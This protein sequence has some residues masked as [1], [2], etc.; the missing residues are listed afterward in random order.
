MENLVANQ[1]KIMGA[2]DQ[3][4]S[5]YKKDGPDRKTTYHIKKRLSTLESYWQEFQCNHIKLCEYED[6]SHE[7][8]VS[9]FYKRTSEFYQETRAYI[10]NQLSASTAME[11]KPYHS[12]ATSLTASEFEQQQQIAGTSRAE[13]PTPLRQQPSSINV[14]QNRGTISKLEE[15]LRKQ[16]S[17][18]RAFERTINIINFE[19]VSEKWEFEDIL[20]SIHSRWSV[21]DSLH[22]EIDSELFEPNEEYEQAFSK[23]EKRF[24]DI[25]RFINSKMW[26]QVNREKATPQMD[27][28]TFSGSYHSWV[29]FKDLFTETIHSNKSLSKAQKMQFLKSKLKGEAEKLIQH[30]NI[31]SDNY[32]ISWDI[33]NHRFNNTK[34]I[35]NSHLSILMNLPTLQQQTATSI[36]KIHD[37]TNEC[38]NAIRSLGVQIDSWDPIIVYIICN[39][40]DAD[41][42]NDYIES[43][44]NPRDL[45]SLK[46]L[47]D[48][49]ESKFT[50][51]ESS[52]RKPET[53]K[54]YHTQETTNNNVKKPHY[55]KSFA[56]RQK[57]SAKHFATANTSKYELQGCPVCKKDHG[58][59][60]CDTFLELQPNMKQQTITKLSLCKNCLY[61]HNDKECRS[62]KK[63]RVCKEDHN[64]LLHDVFGKVSKPQ[65]QND[66]RMPTTQYKNN[67]LQEEAGEVLLATALVKVRA[68]DGSY[69]TLRALIDQGS[70]VGLI[71]ENAA[72]LLGLQRKRC[73]G[74]I[75]G[76]GAKESNCKGLASLTISSMHNDYTF[77]TDVFI[78]KQLIN[79]LPN[80]SFVKPSWPF[81]EN[82]N[83]ADPEF[84]VSRQVDILLGADTYSN[85]ILSGIIRENNT[86]PIAQQSQ[87]G[88]ILFGCANTTES[89]HCNVALIDDLDIQRFWTIEDVSDNSPLSA[90]DQLCLEYYKSTTQRQTDGTY[91]V[92]L[93]LHPDIDEKLGMSRP[94]A[95][96]QFHQLE[97]KFQKQPNVAD[98]YKQFMEEYTKLG[99]MH[100]TNCNSTE[101]YY[102]AHHCVQ[103]PG[104]T[105]SA[106]RVVY[107]ASGATTTG[108]SLN[109]LMY[110]GP[111][112]QQDLLS[113][114]IRWR[115]YKY[116]FTADLEKM[117]RQILVHPDD[118][119]YQKIVWRPSPDQFLQDY[120]LSTVTYG[121]KAAPFLAM[122]TLRQLATDE[123][124]KFPIAAKALA[125]Q[126]YMDDLLSGSHNIETAKQLQSDLLELLKSANFNLRKWSSNEKSLLEHVNND[127]KTQENFDF[128]HQESTKALGLVWVPKSDVFTFQNKTTEKSLSKP[129]KRALLAEISKTF[130]PLGWLAPVTL[131]L[132]LLFQEVWVADLNWDDKIPDA[133]FQAWLKIKDD[134]ANINKIK[135]PRWIHSKQKS[136]IQLHG[137]SD[138]SMKGYSS[139][140]YARVENQGV[141]SVTLLVA[142]TKI[143]PTSKSKTEVSLPRL[144]LCGAQLLSKLMDKITPCLQ[145][146]DLEIYGWTDSTAVLGWL[147]GEP[148]RWKPFVANRVQKITKVMPPEC[149][150]YIKTKENPADCASRGMSVEQLQ[151]HSLWWNGPPALLNF[152]K[153]GKQEQS[154]FT[155]DL[156]ARKIIHTNVT[157]TDTVK[158]NIIQQLIDK[159]STFTR[160]YRVLAWIRRA[161]SRD[162][163][164][165]PYL[166]A[167]ELRSAKLEII[168]HMQHQQYSE[169]ISNLKEN[170]SVNSKSNILSLNPFLDENDLL[171][172]K[173]R[174]RNAFISNEMKYPLII[175]HRGQLTNLL[176]DHAHERTLHGT[177]RTTTSR[178]RE[179]YWIVGGN[180]AVKNRLQ[181]CVTCKKQKAK[182]LQQLM[183]DLPASR[184]NPSR[185]FYHTGVDYTGF[186][187]VKSSKGRGIKST[188]GYVAVFVCMVTKA[189]HLELV[190]DLTASAFLAALRRMSA[191]RGAPR[192]LYSDNGTN[193]IGS[194]KKLQGEILDM[195]AICTKE[196]FTDISEMEITWH[197]NAPSWPS[198]GGL[199]EA[200]VKSLKHHLRRVVGDQKLTYEEYATLLAQIEACLNARPLCAISEDPDDINYLTP[201]HF[202]AS[203]PTLTIIETERDERTRWELTQRIFHDLWKR[204][205]VEYLSQLSAR[206]KWRSTQP[207]I[208][209]DDVVIIHDANLAASKWALGRVIE[210]HPGKDGLVRVVSLKT[211]A[212]I[213]KRPVV[214]LSIL[215]TDS[216]ETPAQSQQTQENTT[217]TSK[218]KSGSKRT[219][220]IK[221][222]CINFM[223]TIFLLFMLVTTSAAQSAYNI[224]ALPISNGIYFDKVS[225]MRLVQDQWKLVVY[226]NMDPYWQG[227][228]VLTG[229]Y[230]HLQSMC[231]LIIERSH[232]DIILLQLQHGFVEL[233]HYDSIL[234]YQQPP[235]TTRARRG[236]IDGVGYLAHTLF[237]VLDERFAEQYQKDITMLRNKQSHLTQYWKKQTSIVEA[238]NNLLKR[239]EGTIEKQHK[240]FNQHLLKLENAAN[241]M[242]SEVQSIEI[243][244][245]FMLSSIIANNILMNLKIIQDSLIDTITNSQHFNIHL[246]K[247]AQLRDELSTISGQL[248]K[249]LSLPV[250]NIQTDLS[251]L[252]QM[253]QVKARMTAQYFIFEL[254]IPLISRDCYDIYKSVPISRQVGNDMVSIIPS[255]N[256]FAMDI[257]KDTYMTI[258]DSE[259]NKCIKIDTTIYVCEIQKPV[260]QRELDKNLCIKDQRENKC[261]I[262]Y[263]TCQHSW[264]ELIR[265]NTFMLTCCGHCT[266]RIICAHQVAT[267]KLSGV[268]MVALGKDCVIKG[269]SFTVTSHTEHTSDFYIKPEVVAVEIAPVNYLINLSIPIISQYNETNFSESFKIISKEIN[270][271]KEAEEQLSLDDQISFHD[272]HHYVAI[273]II[274]VAGIACV[275]YIYLCRRR[276]CMTRRRR[277]PAPPAPAPPVPEPEVSDQCV[278]VKAEQSE[279]PCSSGN[280]KP[281]VKSVSVYSV[282]TASSPIFT[283]CSFT[284]VNS[285]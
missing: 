80:K 235:Q 206:S 49:L 259:L 50:S 243:M 11:E 245:E 220:T 138:S 123:G 194:N 122:M 79:N 151:K 45:P 7:Y 176:I 9:D 222:A 70:Q 145:E 185:P 254:Q 95:I 18:F 38:L 207:N 241:V 166:T 22:W 179:Q 276:A 14:P 86:S 85:I 75:F 202:L 87:L 8:F 236:L 84:Y 116:A 281:G 248:S 172:V 239:I 144:E 198:A 10:I 178:I 24:H 28:P 21:I 249:D 257:K 4:L 256:Y 104:S 231:P 251:K 98:G 180:R 46:E 213:I 94:K 184:A 155:T 58:I 200:A 199:W 129:T 182:K 170:G 191:R 285:E 237:G 163:V 12:P 101:G 210:L 115:Q 240:I 59:F 34:L 74:V 205:R 131:R 134:L 162:R 229:Y 265:L 97:R 221:T 186:L 39:K 218:S 53:S 54:I 238:E 226:Y 20:K 51:L 48:F 133:T 17:N 260:Y 269:D 132:K 26:S 31:S 121:T 30:L 1:R 266:L 197:F 5:N 141:V 142:K 27:I 154:I 32:D 234:Q 57:N 233:E 118:Q 107:N 35:F 250:N 106:L 268:N 261:K 68:A 274:A 284:K 60:H 77:C 73:K 42:H 272:V 19:T 109:D 193:F 13:E 23:Y 61:N 150:R 173:G 171:R 140:I 168:K 244:N 90:E 119:K 136:Q 2:M 25:K 96:A 88:W 81:L 215:P 40:L 273:Y 278:S 72:Q 69:Q 125:E 223:T 120:A 149:W 143:V 283:R 29:S 157:Q 230:H 146:H 201:A 112:L 62:N 258:S 271:T 227:K 153:G 63:C 33:L 137:Y 228:K 219:Q 55:Y 83:L 113:L 43:L 103:R 52:K 124:H 255:S 41:T 156:E 108:V 82:I 65:L 224:T 66:T 246:F 160:T 159:Y 126:F 167:S 92:R 181:R 177:A 161:I 164:K 15:M 195:K 282:N 165:L 216:Q 152:N 275:A 190:S 135:I 204:W 277:G 270:Q 130:D 253:L 212:G 247:P 128:R 89:Y 264:A 232:C 127:S 47:L 188:K 139:V 189:V 183:G 211:K 208:K 16:N 44:K 279:V 192:H 93:P 76:V 169:D 102:M 252:Y 36:K 203:G 214:K 217:E 3:L 110:R 209:I 117:F 225:S 100:Q 175:P 187:D 56:S 78:M 280:L 242:K 67:V 148:G 114:V 174:L 262:K 263:S 91:V 99:H 196:F 111:N 71:S 6:K 267:E 147:Q 37:I 105:T 64:T 158:Q